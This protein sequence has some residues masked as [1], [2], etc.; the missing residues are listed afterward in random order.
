LTAPRTPAFN[1]LPQHPPRWL[2]GQSRLAKA[3][4]KKIDHDFRLRAR[5][6][7]SV[8]QM[9]GAIKN[10]LAK[11]RVAKHTVLV[12]SSDNGY[13][14]GEYRLHSG[15]QTAFD[16]DVNVP[17]VVQGPGIAHGLVNPE[18][19]QNTD[20]APTFE[21]F[22]GLTPSRDRDGIS[23]AGLLNGHPPS[24]WPTLALIEHRGAYLDP[25]DPDYSPSASGGPPS[26]KAIRSRFY[27]YVSYADGDKEYY[28]RSRDPAQLN[29]IYGLLSAQ[30]RSELA[31]IL[32]KLQM[33]RGADACTSARRPG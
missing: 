9:I 21:Q 5:E 16:T 12:F 2:S 18:V 17:L 20:L 31:E 25:D 11:A 3:G 27:T 22:A 13:H 26:Y 28:D 29:N 6:V 24:Q 19:I 8:D 1:R 33:C 23:F 15:K 10:A 32:T 4:R 30:R 14:M 7:L